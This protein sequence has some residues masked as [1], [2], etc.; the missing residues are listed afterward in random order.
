MVAIQHARQNKSYR[1]EC[2]RVTMSSTLNQFVRLLLEYFCD[3]ASAYGPVSLPECESLVHLQGNVIFESQC[4]GCVI[5]R[6]HHLLVCDTGRRGG[7]KRMYY[8]R[9][10]ACNE[11]L[12]VYLA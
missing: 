2:T 7:R 1:S 10:A 11:R 12:N 9:S 5:A 6:H 8:V 3:D 4:Q